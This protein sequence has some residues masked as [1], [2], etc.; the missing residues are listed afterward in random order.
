MPDQASTIKFNAPVI[1]VLITL[2]SAVF[3]A[4][5]A[6]EGEVNN[7]AKV[8]A[9]ETND[10]KIVTDRFDRNDR[11]KDFRRQALDNRLDN[12]KKEVFARVEADKQ[13][14]KTRFENDEKDTKA[15]VASMN[16]IDNRL[17]RMEAQI[18][19]LVKNVTTTGRK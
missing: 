12:D 14:A 18:D 15:A 11:D 7:Y 1:A 8:T 6:W 5:G 10:Y 13:E 3:V 4:G 19:L 2:V 9:Q 17:S 16:S